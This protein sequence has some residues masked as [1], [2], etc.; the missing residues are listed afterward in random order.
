MTLNRY[1]YNCMAHLAS[2]HGALDDTLLLY[3][4]M[5]SEA[6]QQQQR[7]RQQQQQQQLQQAAA[8]ATAGTAAGG[9]AAQREEAE[10]EAAADESVGAAFSGS[11][12]GHSSHNGAAYRSHAPE[13]T[14]DCSPDAY[15]YSAL[16]RA[17]VTAGRGDLLPALFNEMAASQRAADRAAGRPRPLAPGE[18]E[19]RLGLSTEVWGHFISAASRTGQ[20]ELAMRFFDAGIAELGLLPTTP[21]YNAALAAMARAGRPLP[22]LMSL[23]REMVGGCSRPLPQHQQQLQQQQHQQQQAAAA[24]AAAP[25]GAGP[26]APGRGG[27]GPAATRRRRRAAAAAVATAAAAAGGET[28]AEPMAAVGDAADGELEVRQPP[29]RP[30]AYTFNALLT[31]TAHDLAP[32]AAVHAVR[33]EMVA[34]GVQLNTYVGTSLINALRKTPELSRAGG[35]GAGAAGGSAAAGA[36]AVVSEAEAVMS[37]LVAGGAA[38]ATSYICMAALY[39][40]A[41]QPGDVLRVVRE[42][43][44]G[45]VVADG[46]SWEFLV[47]AAEDAGLYGL[48]PQLQRAAEAQACAAEQAAAAAAAETSRRRQQARQP[49]QGQGQRQSG[50]LGVGAVEGAGDAVWRASE[51]GQRERAEVEKR[52]VGEYFDRMGA[53]S[54]QRQDEWQQRRQQQQQQHRQQQQH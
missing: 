3:N 48:V 32:L 31:A 30:D 52:R 34:H 50:E 44:A 29:L 11:Q 18:G 39:A 24:A 19:G 13:L 8:T 35:A 54:R 7:H 51:E 15:T 43:V 37:E 46:S 27:G 4:M 47:A 17:A 1:A 49:G 33:S 22:E 36:A 45:G 25:D 2:L 40:S 16:V 28:E 6:R 14:L 42:M 9:A 10:P 23:Y 38:S 20:P 53:E 41:R 26:G 21:I 5:R 12:G